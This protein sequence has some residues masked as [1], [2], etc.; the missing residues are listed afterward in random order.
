MA[1]LL[2]VA[3][4]IQGAILGGFAVDHLTDRMQQR[5][6]EVHGWCPTCGKNTTRTTP[7]EDLP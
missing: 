3:A 7:P 5:W 6:C 4:L 2:F 1:N